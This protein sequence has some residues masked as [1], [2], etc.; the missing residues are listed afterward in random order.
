LL[1]LGERGRGRRRRR[2]R[3]RRRSAR[4]IIY[5]PSGGAGKWVGW[6]G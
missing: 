5:V 6:G 4:H 2:R 1:L 3:R